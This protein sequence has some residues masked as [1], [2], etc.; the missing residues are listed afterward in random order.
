[1]TGREEDIA[2]RETEV[3]SE[4]RRRQKTERHQEG[5]VGRSLFILGAGSNGSQAVVGDELGF[6][7]PY[8]IATQKQ[9]ISMFQTLRI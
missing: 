8:V 5:N 4:N 7:M 3:I 6:A 2:G 1:M 9:S